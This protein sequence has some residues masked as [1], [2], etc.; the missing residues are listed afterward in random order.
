[1]NDKLW[2]RREREIYLRGVVLTALM[3][4]GGPLSLGVASILLVWV[5][6][7]HVS[8]MKQQ[9]KDIQEGIKK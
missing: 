6:I 5:F 7:K 1:M 2:T 9:K 8:A 3:V 4:A